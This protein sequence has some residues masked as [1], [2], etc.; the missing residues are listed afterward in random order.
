MIRF[1]GVWPRWAWIVY[2]A[3]AISLGGGLGYVVG[4]R[5]SAAEPAQ[6]VA[7]APP[8]QPIVVTPAPEPAPTPLPEIE[9]TPDPAKP[10]TVR[11]PAPPP[12]PKKAKP[13]KPCND[14]DHMDGC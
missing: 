10:V 14:Y 8:V 11:R 12:R 4:T 6:A 5:E 3:L 7:P 13:S 2:P 9:I 1:A